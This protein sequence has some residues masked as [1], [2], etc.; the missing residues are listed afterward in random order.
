[1]MF[2]K[3]I[4]QFE[5]EVLL[6]QKSSSS[7]VSLKKNFLSFKKKC[8]ANGFKK[9]S[10]VWKIEFNESKKCFIQPKKLSEGYSFSNKKR[11]RSVSTPFNLYNLKY[12]ETL[13]IVVVSA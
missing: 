8:I 3:K 5:K 13:V 1:M 7:K 12:Y 11:R 4:T 10:W 2:E 9:V 6:Q